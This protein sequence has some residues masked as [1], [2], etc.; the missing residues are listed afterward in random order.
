MVVEE[1]ELRGGTTPAGMLEMFSPPDVPWSGSKR[2]G[3][4]LSRSAGSE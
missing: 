2:K 1:A 4:F 3:R